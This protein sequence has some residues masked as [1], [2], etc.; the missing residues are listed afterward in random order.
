MTYIQAVTSKDHSGSGYINWIGSLFEQIHLPSYVTCHSGTSALRELEMDGLVYCVDLIIHTNTAKSLVTG[1]KDEDNNL[2]SQIGL[3]NF[4]KK[5]KHICNESLHDN[6]LADAV[7][8]QLESNMSA[9]YQDLQ[10]VIA[11]TRESLV[12]AMKSR[13]PALSLNMGIEGHRLALRFKYPYAVEMVRLI[14]HLDALCV[15]LMVMH[16]E[17]MLGK[18][19]I[20][21]IKRRY[22]KQFRSIIKLVETWDSRVVFRRREFDS[23]SE[24][25]TKKLTEYKGARNVEVTEDILANIVA[26]QW[27]T[28]FS[29]TTE[30]GITL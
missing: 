9:L 26:P 4:S 25:Q 29:Q 20:Y 21:R 24:R 23:L 5:I 6:P 2:K 19:S 13:K 14:N 1:F 22:T 27:L 30:A 11:D 15:L 17:S 10:D 12:Q 18:D 3:N 28:L 7:L 8:I 16:R